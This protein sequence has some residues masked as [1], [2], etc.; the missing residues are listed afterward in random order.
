ML[1]L[2]VSIIIN[3]CGSCIHCRSNCRITSLQ[4]RY[5]SCKFYFLGTQRQLRSLKGLLVSQSI[6]IFLSMASEAFSLMLAFANYV[7]VILLL[8]QIHWSDTR[9]VLFCSDPNE[10]VSLSSLLRFSVTI[11]QEIDPTFSGTREYKL[12]AVRILICPFFLILVQCMP[13][14]NITL[15]LVVALKYNF[16]PLL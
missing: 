3:F 6:I 15:S 9:C 10:L 4:L 11:F 12:L 14:P 8:S 5:F 2:I 16:K 7:E 13:D 1:Y